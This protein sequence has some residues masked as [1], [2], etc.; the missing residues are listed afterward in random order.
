M[1]Y[2]I[3][4]VHTKIKEVSKQIIYAQAVTIYHNNGTIYIHILIVILTN[5]RG[6]NGKPFITFRY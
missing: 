6:S 3:S 1:I 5:F 2:D 4:T